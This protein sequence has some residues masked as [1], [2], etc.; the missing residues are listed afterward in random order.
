MFK[1]NKKCVIVQKGFF[2]QYGNL[3]IV[4][5]LVQ[6]SEKFCKIDFG[7]KPQLILLG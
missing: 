3:K 5:R 6:T 7:L 2:F 1:G 4:R